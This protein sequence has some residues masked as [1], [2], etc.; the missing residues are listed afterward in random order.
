MA[1]Y[2][3][4]DPRIWNDAKF[5]S[6][7]SEAKLL[8]LYLLTTPAMTVVGAIPMRASAV[9]EELGLDSKRY[10]IRYQ[11]LYD[12]GIVEYDERGL[13][14]VKNFLKYNAPDNPK[15]V[16][17]WRNAIDLLPEC[18]LLAKVLEAAKIHCYQRGEGYAESFRKCIPDSTVDGTQDSTAY[19]MPYGMPYQE[20]EQE[21]DIYTHPSPSAQDAS[22]S[23]PPAKKAKRTSVCKP[24]DVPENL[25]CDWIA[26]RKQ[27]RLPLTAQAL[28]LVQSE[29]AKAGK[30]LADVLQI[31][32]QNSWAGFKASWLT[33]AT[34]TQQSERPFYT[35]AHDWEAEREAAK[36]NVVHSDALQAFL[37]RKA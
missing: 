6:L 16:L 34:N 9:A 32:L 37:G 17:S 11:E 28:A 23:T 24:E 25:W 20:Q 21:Q 8:F 30:T 22:V 12:R 1:R 27:K 35:P 33:N 29:A 10:A 13:F 26:L 14:W 36:E 4:I 7:S 5:S 15:V 3:K 18:P 19:G 31:C 2:R